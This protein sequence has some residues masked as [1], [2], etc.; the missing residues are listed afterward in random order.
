MLAMKFFL[1]GWLLTMVSISLAFIYEKDSILIRT[2]CYSGFAMVLISALI[3][4]W[5]A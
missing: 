4:I 2:I 1:T 3:L 5:T